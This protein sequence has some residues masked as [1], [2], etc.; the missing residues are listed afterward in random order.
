MNEWEE[1]TWA[2]SEKEETKVA[3]G[4]EK[5]IISGTQLLLLSSK[6]SRK[7]EVLQ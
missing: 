4:K 1:N 7:I 6:S 3:T 5:K 2:K